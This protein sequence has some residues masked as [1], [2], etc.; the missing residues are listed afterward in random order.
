M[1]V[2]VLSHTKSSISIM[3]LRGSKDQQ[4]VYMVVALLSVAYVDADTMLP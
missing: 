1:P 2:H 3:L 4:Y